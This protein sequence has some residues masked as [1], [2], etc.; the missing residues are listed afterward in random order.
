MDVVV[1]WVNQVVVVLV[2]DGR[3]GH[4]HLFLLGCEIGPRDERPGGS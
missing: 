2:T 4:Q 3:L 1:A